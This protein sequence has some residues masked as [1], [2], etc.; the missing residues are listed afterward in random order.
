MLQELYLYMNEIRS[1]P[2]K[3]NFPL[4][5]ILNINRNTDLASL[6][7]NYCPFLEQISASYCSINHLDSMHG[8]PNLTTLDLSFN[9]M[10]KL[11]SLISKI[12]QCNKISNLTINDN[13]FNFNIQDDLN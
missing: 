5:R 10:P 8:C 2:K 9:K 12:W 13:V 3:L 6:S 11:D 7:L 4:L 1:L